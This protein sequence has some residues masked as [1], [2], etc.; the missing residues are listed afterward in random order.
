MDNYFPTEEKLFSKKNIIT[1]LIL[2]IIVLAIPVGVRIVETQ[3][4]LQSKATGNE[5]TFPDLTRV[6]SAGNPITTTTQIKIKLD[7][8]FG[9]PAGQSRI[10]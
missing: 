10:Q 8:P 4:A 2:A 7:S 3:R 9:P 5:I 6:D 1:Y